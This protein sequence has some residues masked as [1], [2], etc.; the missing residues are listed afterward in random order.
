MTVIYCVTEALVRF[1]G[2][3]TVLR[4]KSISSV[5]WPFLLLS[6]AIPC[7]PLQAPRTP[8]ISRRRSGGLS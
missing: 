5:S 7:Y 1:P 8:E 4:N 3:R 6:P 2:P